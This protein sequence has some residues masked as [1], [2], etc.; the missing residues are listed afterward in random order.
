MDLKNLRDVFHDQMKDMY[1]AEKQLTKALPTLIEAASSPQLKQAMEH[2][3]EVTR[4][5]LETVRQLLDHMDVNPGNTHC[6]AMEG[7]IEEARDM[8]SKDGDP[9]ARD[10]GIICAAQKVE[11]YEIATYGTLCTW[12][13]VLGEGQMADTLQA[14]LDEEYDAD[15]KLDKLAKGF[16]NERAS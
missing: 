7:L 9:M 11:H 14:V 10:A 8:A 12:A 2:H 4:R 13:Q 1:R 15:G 5:H 16:I 3:L 6:D